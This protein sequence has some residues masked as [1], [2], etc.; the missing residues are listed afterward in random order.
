MM[1]RALVLASVLLLA[2]VL[3]GPVPAAAQGQFGAET[4]LTTVQ[5]RKGSRIPRTLGPVTRQEVA[6]A[7]SEPAGTILIS[8]D[9]LTLDLV[10]GGGRALRYRISAGRDG[11]RWTGAT[12][13][14]RKAEWPDWRPPAE[15]RQRAPDL[16][17]MLPAGPL[18]P[19]GARA[20][21]LFKGGRDTLYRIHGTSET[22][23]IQ[24]YVSSGCFRMTNADVID[25]YQ[26][27]G[28]GA[29]VLVH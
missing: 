15:M 6:L 22:G 7:S 12:Y 9:N 11:F 4:D 5:S 17:E 23:S 8:N 16:P 21:Y 29:K 27:V 25:L 28:A 19:L 26:R 10:L 24:D 3:Q 2:L 18:N 1:R 13:V 14:G 20:I